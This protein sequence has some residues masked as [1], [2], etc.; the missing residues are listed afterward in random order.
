MAKDTNQLQVWRI[1]ASCKI[2]FDNTPKL[3]YK[4]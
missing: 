1:P 3:L 4:N 2:M